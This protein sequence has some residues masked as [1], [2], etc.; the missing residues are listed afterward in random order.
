MLRLA[1]GVKTFSI[2]TFCVIPSLNEIDWRGFL[3][4]PALELPPREVFGTLSRKTILIT[5]AGGSIG[6]ALALRL[7]FLVSPSLIL[8]DTSENGLHDLQRKLHDLQ[9]SFGKSEATEPATFILGSAGDR[10]LMEELFAAHEPG[11]V[12]HAAAHKHVPI[13]EEQPLAAI[14]NN[15][16]GTE[17]VTAVAAAHSARVVLLSTDKAVAPASLMGATK[18]VAE[19]MAL[20]SSGTVLRLGNVLGSRGSVTEEFA[21]QIARGGPLTV[22]DP[23]ARR[24]FLTMDEAVNL[25]LIAAA[26]SDFSALLAP[27]LPAT[28]SIVELACFMARELAP[29]RKIAIEFIG[30][31]PGDKLTEMLWT[32]ADHI[33]SVGS[34]NLVSIRPSLLDPMQF[35]SGLAALHAALAER[36]LSAA[37]AQLRLL[38][39]DYRPSET[40]V[41]ILRR[42]AGTRVCA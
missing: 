38:V 2:Y 10:L 23:S 33:H 16:F 24:Y 32:R 19:E 5:G 35:K 9:R 3:A 20:A 28:H 41:A 4:R 25:L 11:I 14:A 18:R 6:S 29:D 34:G 15:V 17:N 42:H 37:I 27:A 22:T 13:V 26:Q 40:M 8:L 21:R 12:F 36:N 39:P 31:R 1:N 30:L 7:A